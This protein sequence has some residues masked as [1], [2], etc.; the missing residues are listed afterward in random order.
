MVFYTSG[1]LY[2]KFCSKT[3][4]RE[5]WLCESRNSSKDANTCISVIT[6]LFDQFWL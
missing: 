6:V 3:E 1:Y 4:L 2:N 5:N